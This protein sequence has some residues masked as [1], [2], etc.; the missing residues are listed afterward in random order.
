MKA[1]FV[2]T[3]NFS[4]RVHFAQARSSGFVLGYVF[5]GELRF[6]IEGEP[7]TPVVGWRAFSKAPGAIHLPSGRASATKPARVL[8]VAFGEKGKELTNSE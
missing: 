4:D 3:A 7:Q 5:E 6:Q 8:V 1:Y 2:V